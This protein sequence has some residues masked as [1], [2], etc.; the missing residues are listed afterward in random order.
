VRAPSFIN[1]QSLPDLCRGALL[2]DPWR[3]SAPR[4]RSARS[5]ADA[6]AAGMAKRHPPVAGDPLFY[7]LS[8]LVKILVVMFILVLPLVTAMII[9]ERK[10]L[11]FISSGRPQP[12]GPWGLLQP[13]ADVVKLLELRT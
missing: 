13:I 5:T 7:V 2:A 10:V 3:S 8:P 12:G 6:V 9:I 11:G 1:L 4:R